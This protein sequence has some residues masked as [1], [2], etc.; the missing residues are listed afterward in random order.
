MFQLFNLYHWIY[1]FITIILFIALDKILMKMDSNKQYKFLFGLSL[2]NFGIHFIKVLLD[3]GSSFTT[4]IYRIALTNLCAVNTVLYPLI[5]K[6]KNRYL[7][8]FFE[9]MGFFSGIIALI[10][11]YDLNG[12][13]PFRVENIR[14]WITHFLLL[15][16]SLELMRTKLVKFNYRTL[17]FCYLCFFIEQGIIHLNNYILYITN[18]TNCIDYS[19]ASFTYGIGDA[20]LPYLGFVKYFIPNIFFKDGIY[21]PVLWLLVPMLLVLILAFIIS[22]IFFDREHFKK[23]FIK[24][25][26]CFKKK[27]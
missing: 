3:I 19:N 15:F 7:L 18:I 27:N 21:T 6:I 23:D 2:I 12:T 5:L 8:N 9:F 13:Q 14:Y 22:I 25:K 1:I 4:M 26:G 17:F 10:F 16:I 20:V 24:I 11:C